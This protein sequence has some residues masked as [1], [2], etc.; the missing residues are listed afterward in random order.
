[1]DLKTCTRAEWNAYEADRK[2]RVGTHGFDPDMPWHVARWRERV[3]IILFWGII[4][5]GVFPAMLIG[6]L[7]L[8]GIVI[9][10]MERYDVQHDSCLKHATNGYEIKECH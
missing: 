7:M 3:G 10:G 4:W 1:M 9:D 6:G 2:A 8:M 5:C